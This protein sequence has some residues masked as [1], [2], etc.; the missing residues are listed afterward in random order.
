MSAGSKSDLFVPTNLS[1]SDVFMSGDPIY[2][3]PDYQRPYSW[4]D[5]QVEQ[6]W[7]D[8]MESYEN[9]K[10]DESIDSNYFLG[11]LIV[12]K[13]D[14]VEDVVDGQQ[15][16][17]TLL[18]L[19]CVLRQTFPQINMAVDAKQ[20]P[21]VVKIGKIKNC[22]A[23][24][25]E[26]TRL[27]LQ[28]DISQASNVEELIF[29]ETIDFSTYEKPTKRQLE[30]DIKYRYQNT[31]CICYRHLT[32]EMDETTAGEFVNYLL[33]RVNMIKIICFDESFAIKLFQVLNDRGMD[34]SA[35]DIIK[36]YLL[37]GLKGDRHTHDIFMH[38]WR[39]CEEWIKDLDVSLTDLFTYYLYYLSGS[40]PKRSLV[41][42]LKDRFRKEDANSIQ[43]IR[44]FKKFM[45]EY[46][47]IFL[48][49]SRMIASFWYLPW[50][51][52]WATILVAIEHVNYPYKAELQKQLR[53][54]LYLNY[55]AG[56]TLNSLKQTL[57]N[58]LAGIK[59]LLPFAEIKAIMDEK[60]KSLNIDHIVLEKL[61]GEVYYEGWL[62]AL[63]AVVEYYQTDEEN[64]SFISLDYKSLNVEHIYPQNPDK[65]SNWKE[66]FPNGQL[67]VNSLGNLTLLSGTKNRA[68]QNFPFYEKILIYQGLDRRGNRT[69]S[70]QGQISVYRIT[71]KIVE[72]YQADLYQKRWNEQAV[73]DRFNYL[74]IEIGEIFD[75]DTTDIL[76]E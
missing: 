11:S 15:R 3:I 69:L 44:D 14:H 52:Y 41:D 73:K 40:N 36:G 58:V 75:L 57:F 32:E 22:I 60:R 47:S 46:R 56:I 10:K 43:I 20:N 49:D 59:S 68:A 30:S 35:S 48:S 50:M 25:N 74:C 23:D 66:M 70:K 26:L 76:K 42:E 6:L 67:Y 53:N 38:D 8:L 27:R 13:K 54:F 1:L 21:S 7:D 31:A 65:N 29:N 55:I 33:N 72:D 45:E 28:T 4:L 9:N 24:T 62:K 12:V 19:L 64:V 5:E 51:T 37:S 18:I 39:I 34:L 61:E 16:L 71:Q 17:T 63:L 2:Q